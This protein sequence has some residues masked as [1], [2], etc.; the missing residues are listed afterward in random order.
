MSHSDSFL[1]IASQKSC[2][3]KIKLGDLSG[4]FSDFSVVTVLCNKA[5]KCV[6]DLITDDFGDFLTS[7]F[8]SPINCDTSS[9]VKN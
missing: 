9:R 6:P 1:L 2:Q 7:S 5:A 8:I 4:F 3:W